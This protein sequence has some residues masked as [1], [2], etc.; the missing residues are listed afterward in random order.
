MHRLAYTFFGPPAGVPVV[1]LHHG[2]GSS[3]AWQAQIPALTQ[4]GFRVLAYDRWG[5]GASEPRP[6]LHTPWFEPDVAD[7]A[8]LL[9]AVGLGQV[10]LVGH[11]DGGTIALY[12]AA[13]YPGRVQA[14]VTVAAHVYVDPTMHPGMEA[15]RQ[16]YETSEAFRQALDRTHQGRGSEV[17]EMWYA[18]WHRPG[19]LD[20]DARPLLRYVKAPTLVVQGTA[21]EYAPPE[22]AQAIAAALPNARLALVPDASHML[23]QKHPDAF[24]PLLLA[25][26]KTVVLGDTA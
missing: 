25:Y 20:W 9:D 4:A 11:S 3:A 6:Q 7:L 1:L 16:V 15:L 5:Y 8:A 13:R 26:L 12:F 18:A 22:H 21:D 2:L 17:F 19:V 23:P 24:N 14:L 10:V